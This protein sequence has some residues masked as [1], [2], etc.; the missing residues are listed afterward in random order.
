M[1]IFGHEPD[2]SGECKPCD[3]GYYRDE[4]NATTYLPSNATLVGTV[5]VGIR[6]DKVRLCSK[7]LALTFFMGIELA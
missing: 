5:T 7:Y 6:A 1:C 3:V 4:L 2:G